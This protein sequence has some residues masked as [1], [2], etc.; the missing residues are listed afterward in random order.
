MPFYDFRE[1]FKIQN[2]TQEK[3]GNQTQAQISK[4]FKLSS[5]WKN[6]L[7]MG[8]ISSPKWS[9]QIHRVNAKSAHSL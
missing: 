2:K 9:S 8:E 7:I 4:A 1:F 3:E 6:G 5:D